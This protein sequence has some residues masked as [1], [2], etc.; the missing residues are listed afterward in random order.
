MPEE[1]TGICD[2]KYRELLQQ[3]NGDVENAQRD[4]D[5]WIK[6]NF[7]DIVGTTV[8]PAEDGEPMLPLADGALPVTCSTGNNTEEESLNVNT[9]VPIENPDAPIQD[10]DLNTAAMVPAPIE[11]PD[12]NNIAV[13]Q[14][15]G[16]TSMAPLAAPEPQMSEEL[17]KRRRLICC[18]TILCHKCGKERKTPSITEPCPCLE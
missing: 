8:K 6:Q 4:L 13:S 18:Y 7:W 16:E 17:A 9:A 14:T 5:I 11:Y 3:Y 10:R 12:V 1:G 2:K 15:V